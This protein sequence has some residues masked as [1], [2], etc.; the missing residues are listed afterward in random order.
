VRIAIRKE[1]FL[2]KFTA[3]DFCVNLKKVLAFQSFS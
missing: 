1:K 2:H 3:R